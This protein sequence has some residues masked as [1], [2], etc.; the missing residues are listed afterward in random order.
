MT[1][2]SSP[3]QSAAAQPSG[4]QPARH[5]LWATGAERRDAG[6]AAREGAG[7]TRLGQW[8]EDERGHDTLQT[9]LAQ[10]Q[11]RVPELAPLRHQRMAASPWNYYRGAAAVMASDLAS[12]PNSGLEVQL[13]GDAHVLNFG[14][15]ATPS[16]TSCSISATSTRPCLDRSSGT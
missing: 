4:A 13:C 2:S 16:G 14:L 5:D 9:I 6:R 8:R 12:R 7:R 15:W 1:E 3:P 11:M 10:N